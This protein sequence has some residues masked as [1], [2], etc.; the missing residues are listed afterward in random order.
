[1]PLPDLLTLRLRFQTLA[2]QLLPPLP[3]NALRGA[4]GHALR[5][6]AC[7]QRPNTPCNGCLHARGCGYPLLF[8]P[9]GRP[10]AG[11]GVT[12]RAPP[13]LVLAPESR[14][15]GGPPIPLADGDSLTVRV[16]L[17]GRLAAAYE[18][19]AI[20]ALRKGAESG[21]GISPADKRSKVPLHLASV[22]RV[23]SL[24][25]PIPSAAEL[26]FVSPVRLHADGKIRGLIEAPQF[27]AA[28]LRRTDTL[29][30]LYGTE[31]FDNLSA[32]DGLR[33]RSRDTH[34]ISVNRYSSRQERRMELPGVLGTF[35]LNGDLASIWP[36][37]L[38]GE[39]VQI[40]KGTSFGFGRYR[41]RGAE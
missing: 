38:F 29:T 6:L 17:V 22:E 28:L 2:P 8:E 32:P 9:P 16:T 15:L 4:L 25:L 12:D 41:L 35:I 10:D 40:G 20:A 27:L 14:V 19:L 37:L 13:P 1:M 3:T 21:V 30:R 33:F 39:R 5:A 26:T 11:L 7:R 18:D 36:S 31:P 24:D 34:V 23:P